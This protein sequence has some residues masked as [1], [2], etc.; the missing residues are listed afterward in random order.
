MTLTTAHPSAAAVILMLILR[1]VLLVYSQCSCSA[2][3]QV[4]MT[5]NE[6]S[7]KSH[8]MAYWQSDATRLTLCSCQ[9]TRHC[10]HSVTAVDEPSRPTVRYGQRCGQCAAAAAQAAVKQEAGIHET[11]QA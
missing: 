3:V 11:K 9:T 6:L 8:S 2:A 10:R 5:V 4:L 7:C 1:I